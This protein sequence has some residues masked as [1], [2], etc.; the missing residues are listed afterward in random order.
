MPRNVLAGV[1]ALALLI[2]TALAL[3][4][5]EVAAQ[6]PPPTLDTTQAVDGP[7]PGAAV[8]AGYG[9][10][11]K[12]PGALDLGLA[13]PQ[14]QDSPDA[15][16]ITGRIVANGV[17]VANTSVALRLWNGT[18]ESTVSTATTDSS[19]TY[20]FINP[21]TLASGSTYYVLYGPNQNNPAYVF[22]WFGPDI[23]SYSSGQT[24]SVADINVA[25]ITLGAPPDNTTVSL[26]TTFTW[27]KRPTTTD[28]YRLGLF[29]ADTGRGWLMPTVYYN[30]IYTL[31]SSSPLTGFQ[32]GKLYVWTVLAYDSADTTSYGEDFDEHHITFTQAAAA[33]NTPTRTATPAGVPAT[34]TTTMTPVPNVTATVSR[35]PT[36]TVSPNAT[37]AATITPTPTPCTVQF[38]TGKWQGA[39]DFV[40]SN[41]RTHVENF[42]TNV[43][44]AGTV[45]GLYTVRAAQLP[46]NNCRIE[47]GSQNSSVTI[48]G[49]G[50]FTS[51]DEMTGSNFLFCGIGLSSGTWRSWWVGDGT[52]DTPTPTPTATATATATM[53]AT[54]P[55]PN[56]PT[57]TAT[58]PPG[59]DTPTVTATSGPTDTATPTA[60]RTLTPTP[61]AT[62]T[63]TPTPTATPKPRPCTQPYCLIFPIIMR[64][65]YEAQTPGVVGLSFTLPTRDTIRLIW[66][67]S[68]HA[69]AY[70]LW[71]MNA[72]DGPQVIY[73]GSDL[74]ATLPGQPVGTY[75]FAVDALGVW[76]VT[77]SNS[78]TVV[79]QPPPTPTPTATLVPTRTPTS[80]PTPRPTATPH[81]PVSSRLRC[82][83]SDEGWT[84]DIV[85]ES[86]G[87][88]GSYVSFQFWDDLRGWVYAFRVER[89]YLNSNRTYHMDAEYW[90]VWTGV[91]QGRVWASVTGGVF[92]NNAQYCQNF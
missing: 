28:W 16:A 67:V 18:S 92:G 10:T 3:A 80:T 35:T 14:A 33:T 34:A 83:A 12:H 79:V 72:P 23:T 47:F 78:V 40:V 13:L 46:I 41:D 89:T 81:P 9:R 85:D 74:E 6:G 44:A 54:S 49:Q 82:G 66:S 11:T 76:G 75:V 17:G 37:S 62:R 73:A 21:G 61:T 43:G 91:L 69:K 26:P 24:L 90:R 36:P 29:A 77:G 71:L 64:R 86:G 57:V 20:T 65:G 7:P 27:T 39:A 32:Y 2:A 55:P 1:L 19:G 87:Y 70:R 31:Q 52:T 51:S 4:Q 48:S 84:L 88:N 56:T 45:C 42:S 58:T 30:D 50:T 68:D 60:T 63:L 15:G 38:K 59:A 8:L 53:T 25:A 22:I 5:S